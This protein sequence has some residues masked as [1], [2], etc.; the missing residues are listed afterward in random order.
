MRASDAERNAMV[1]VLS[2]AVSEG[3]LTLE[4]YSERAGTAYAAKTRAD[5]GGIIDDLPHGPV[6][7][8]ASNLPAPPLEGGPAL[9]QPRQPI[10]VRAAPPALAQSHSHRV[11]AVLGNESRKG[12]WVVPERMQVESYLGDCHLE[13][14]EALLEHPVTT[15]DARAV[16]G[17]VT[18]FVP[19]GVD[20]R[21]I[22]RVV[23]GSK[24]C[25]LRGTPR[26]G[27]PVLIVQ[28]DVL[29]GS[30]TVQPPR[31]HWRAGQHR[32]G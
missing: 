8:L 16:L 22:G 28:C 5:L 19:D 15:I 21:L 23:L 26:P 25:K 12:R 14:Q 32:D 18:I 17:S 11:V 7:G 10:P 27:A 6:L 24:E 4:E 20:V 30:V 13:L 2:Q 31:W 1:E 29:L 9:G 3:R